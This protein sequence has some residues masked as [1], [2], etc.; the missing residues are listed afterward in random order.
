MLATERKGDAVWWLDH[1]PFHGG[2]VVVTGNARRLQ[3]GDGN[4]WV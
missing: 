4:W 1:V 2:K 3:A